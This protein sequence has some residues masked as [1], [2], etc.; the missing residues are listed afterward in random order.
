MRKVIV[1]QLGLYYLFV[2]RETITVG[3]LKLQHW[4]PDVSS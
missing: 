2:E 3:R 4:I 1:Y